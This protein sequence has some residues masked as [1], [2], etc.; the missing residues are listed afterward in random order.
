MDDN[1]KPAYQLSS[2]EER[3]IERYI[4]LPAIR[5]ALEHDRKIIATSNV[6]FKDAY[7]KIFEEALHRVVSDMK[8]NKDEIFDHHIQ[9]TKNDWFNYDAY[10]RGQTFHIGYH[11]NIAAD[12]IY[13]HIGDYL[14]ENG[15]M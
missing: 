10:L 4:F 15:L 2:K 11:K 3:I 6:K 13:L 5:L 1:L 14:K 9:L 7:D 8:K 12:W